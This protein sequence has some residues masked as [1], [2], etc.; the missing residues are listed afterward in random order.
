MPNTLHSV[1]SVIKYLNC[2]FVGF[3]ASIVLIYK[4]LWIK[5]S[6]KFLKVDVISGLLNHFNFYSDSVSHKHTLIAP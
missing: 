2:S 5:A 4:S 1:G 6:A 3:V